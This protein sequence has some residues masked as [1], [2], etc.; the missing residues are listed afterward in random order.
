MIK[1]QFDLIGLAS[2]QLAMPRNV[3]VY[4]FRIGASSEVDQLGLSINGQ[5]PP[6]PSDIIGVNYLTTEPGPLAGIHFPMG[7]NGGLSEHKLSVRRPLLMKLQP[8]AVV[9]AFP[10]RYL[11]V[12]GYN[13]RNPHVEIEVL[14]SPEEAMWM[15][16]ERAPHDVGLTYY[17]TTVGTRSPWI[18]TLGRRY[19]T[20]EMTSDQV[21][22]DYTV[23]G[24]RLIRD[25]RNS[26]FD[27]KSTELVPSG[28]VS[29][30][31][32]EGE[33]D[34]DYIIAT[35]TAATNPTKAEIHF[36]SED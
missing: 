35:I 22:S 3:P 14:T 33:G 17:M 25:A 30:S 16:T 28:A 29:S 11:D 1:L 34:F 6:F 27:I 4:G 9:H 24:V 32:Y 20:I 19:H 10:T 7:F 15:P 12:T 5:V 18:W 2:K 13:L 21:L 36:R 31:A 26:T 23:S 8:N